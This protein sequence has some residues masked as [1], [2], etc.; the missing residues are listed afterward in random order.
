MEVLLGAESS[1]GSNHRLCEA[2]HA[3]YGVNA[4][5]P[6]STDPAMTVKKFVEGIV[7]ARSRVLHGTLSTLAETAERTRATTEQMAGDF[8][9]R[10]AIALDDYSASVAPPDNAEALLAWIDT[11]RQAIAPRT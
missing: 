7:G 5:D 3:F 1:K 11:K 10:I 6:L 9:R 2:L 4:T 8:L